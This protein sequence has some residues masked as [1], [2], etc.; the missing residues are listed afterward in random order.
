MTYTAATTSTSDD[1][2]STSGTQPQ[3]ASH[4]KAIAAITLGNGLEFFDFTI[5][6]FFAT[7]IGKL[8]FP[9]E[10]QLAQLMLAVGT[11]GVGFIM[12]PVG[13][14]V[15]GAYADRAGRKAAMSLTLWLMTL[16]S[17]IIAFAPTYASIGLAAPVLVIL[18]RLIQGFAL[19]GEIGAST[20][21]LMEYGSDRT[22]GFYG[23]WQFVSQGL[24]TVVGS[25]LG[26]ALAAMLST[27]ALESWGW[28]VPFVIGMAMG[29]IGV[30]IR[31]HLDET[32]P[33]PAASD[34]SPALEA[35]TVA[36]PVR[37][38]FG[39][40]MGSIVTGVVTTIGGTAA[41]Y[42]VLFY[43]STYAIKILHM[44]MS[45]ALWASWTAAL[46]TVICSPFAGSLSDR[47]GRKRVLWVSRVLLIAGV[48]PAFMVI[49]AVPTVPVLLSVV[50]VLGVLVAFTAVP[51]IVM[52]PEMF[53]REIRATGMSIVYCLGVSIFGG[54][55]QFF[56]TWL[57]Q[58]SGNTLAPAWYLIGCGLVSLLALPFVRETAGRAI[59]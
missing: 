29:P 45:L 58:L 20:S 59:D 47:Y 4:A 53:P 17:A 40:H 24:N 23:S 33:L 26:V 57:I 6:S 7:I 12:R 25:L 13:G 19:G 3:R 54:F 36:K 11:F 10:G 21:L 18:A 51:N 14:V 30:Y 46:V 16:G 39:T 49:N 15:L 48:Y 9:V 35:A 31:R 41:N 56:A 34:H 2:V 8:Y 32:L 27:H 38:I 50:A 52:L 44:P 42:I 5:Y 22:R 43:L 37:E 28:R 55:A 1:S